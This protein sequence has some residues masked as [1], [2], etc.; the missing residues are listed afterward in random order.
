MLDLIRC[1]KRAVHIGKLEYRRWQLR[2]SP[3]TWVLTSDLCRPLCDLG[4]SVPRPVIL[5]FFCNSSRR[6]RHA[7]YAE[8]KSICDQEKSFIWSPN[9]DEPSV[10]EQVEQVM[11]ESKI[12]QLWTGVRRKNDGLVYKFLHFILKQQLSL[13][14]AIITITVQGSMMKNPKLFF[15]AMRL[16]SVREV[17]KSA[18]LKSGRNQLHD[19]DEPS[20]ARRVK[21]NLEPR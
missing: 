18:S 21:L 6:L 7:T 8:A 2:L 15:K 5:P 1:V 11:A 3:S 12:F 17:Q 19:Y 20:L 4:I 10:Y 14:K 9:I 13:S 16:L